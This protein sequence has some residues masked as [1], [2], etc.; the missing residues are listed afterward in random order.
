MQTLWD[1]EVLLLKGSFPYPAFREG[2]RYRIVVGGMSHVG[3]G[4]GYRIYLNGR[5]LQERLTG[6][7][8][9]A[10]AKPISCIIDKSWWG[11]F[12]TGKVDI[13]VITFQGIK[14]NIK[15]ANFSLWI[16]EMK[17]P[18]LGG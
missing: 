12:M 6:V 8:K 4:E 11:E 16:Q 9:R 5:L 14:K 18:P 1:K 13:S 2:Y 17:V 15:R 7:E 10:G 3:A